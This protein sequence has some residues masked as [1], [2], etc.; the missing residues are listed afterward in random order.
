MAFLG[1]P[2]PA[3]PQRELPLHSEP[4]TDT[5]PTAGQTARRSRGAKQA[6]NPILMSSLWNSNQHHSGTPCPILREQTG[7]GRGRESPRPFITAGE[8]TWLRI[9]VP[10]LQLEKLKHRDAG[11]HPALTPIPA[12]PEPSSKPSQGWRP[13]SPGLSPGEAT[14]SLSH[15]SHRPGLLA[16]LYLHGHWQGGR[17]SQP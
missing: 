2:H 3:M 7:L 16:R 11:S 15:P 17:Q 14:S 6:S 1:R 12:A 5:L 8:V 9:F 4:W 10:V 13:P